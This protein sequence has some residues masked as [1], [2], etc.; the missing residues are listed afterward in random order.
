MANEAETITY[1]HLVDMTE[2]SGEWTGLASEAVAAAVEYLDAVQL[3]DGDYTYLAE[4]T[5]EWCTVDADDMA[6]AGAA[7][8]A[9]ADD[10]YSTWCA[11]TPMI[12]T[13]VALAAEVEA[14]VGSDG[15]DGIRVTVDAAL[16]DGITSARE[17]AAIV[18]QAREEWAAEQAL[19][20]G[21]V[22]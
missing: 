12:D 3:D 22:A 9:G 4:E 15:S 19:E 11:V 18:R 10:W 20:K 16:R 6:M 1:T 17:I 2:T 21:E 13:T 8:V 7:I 5:G 14:I